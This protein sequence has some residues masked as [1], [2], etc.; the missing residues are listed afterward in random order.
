M[1][2]CKVTEARVISDLDTMTYTY[3]QNH[4]KPNLKQKVKK[5]MYVKSVVMSTK[6]MFFQKISF[7]HYVNMVL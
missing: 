3:Y 1:F 4:V 7:V 5:V 2:I 6:V